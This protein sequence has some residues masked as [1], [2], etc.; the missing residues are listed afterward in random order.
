MNTDYLP[1]DGFCISNK[2]HVHRS[3]TIYQIHAQYMIL[4][5]FYFGGGGGIAKYG[6]GR[7]INNIC[8][9]A[10]TVGNMPLPPSNTLHCDHWRPIFPRSIVMTSTQRFWSRPWTA[11]ARTTRSTDPT[12]DDSQRPRNSRPSSRGTQRSKW[13]RRRDGGASSTTAQWP[14]A[15]THS[16]ESVLHVHDELLRVIYDMYLWIRC[17]RMSFLRVSKK[18]NITMLG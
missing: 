8:G 3:V 11:L 9:Q 4:C 12:L 10:L 18:I 14:P 16:C 17:S 13:R 6:G 7:G 15:S 2:V 1:G 5:S